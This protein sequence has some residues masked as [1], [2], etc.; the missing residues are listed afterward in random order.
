MKTETLQNLPETGVAPIVAA[1]V[2][3]A[4]AVA[5]A[6]LWTMP[7]AWLVWLLRCWGMA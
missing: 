6:T 3:A 2:G 7:G 4:L 1:A 5:A